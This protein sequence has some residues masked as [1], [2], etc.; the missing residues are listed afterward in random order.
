MHNTQAKHATR[1]QGAA[2][3]QGGFT[4]IELMIAVVIVSILAAIALPS[5]VDYVKRGKLAEAFGE[6]ADYRV[7]M[8]Q[9]YQDNRSYA[10]PDGACGAV[11]PAGKYFDVSCETA[12]AGQSYV[13]T[14]TSKSGAGLGAGYAYTIDQANNKQ[15]TAFEG[16][17]TP[18]G[19]WLKK[20]GESC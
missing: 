5:Y 10:T 12:D 16:S 17:I 2:L 9:F 3:R 4:L 15:T 13:A 1:H 8:E 7:K 6:L 11:L 14:A 19:C 20:K 18:E